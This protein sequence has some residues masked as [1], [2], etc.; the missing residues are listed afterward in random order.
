MHEHD[1]HHPPSSLAG[2][3]RA[4]GFV[5]RLVE[6][7]DADYDEARASWNGAVDRRPAAIAFASDAED[8]AAA[9]RAARA[10]GVPFTIRAGGHSVAGRSVRDGALCIDLRALNGVAGRSRTPA[11][12]RVGGGA[13]LGEVDAATQ[14]HGLAVPAGQISHTGVGGLTLGGGLGWLMRRH[15]LTIDSLV[16]AEVV[17]ADGSIVQASAGEH[18]DLF[19]ALRGGGGDFGGGHELRVPA[20]PRRPDRA[21]RDARLPVGAGGRRAAREPGADGGRPGGADDVR[22]A[23]HRAAARRRS[24]P[25]CRGS[26]SPSS[27]SR[28]AATSPTGERA[29]APLRTGLPP[30]LDLVGPMPYVALQSMLDETAPHGWNFYDRQHYLPEVGDDFIDDAAG[31][32]RARSDAARPRHDRRG[33]AAR[34]IA[35]RRARRRSGTARRAR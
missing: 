31:R 25:S 9:I 4:S 26:P 28:G 23:D 17:L 12:V 27:P 15:G 24:P 33:W 30:A 14:E 29:L 32:L 13:L 6:P 10:A 21:R 1:N 11:L 20:R 7:A 5:G 22:G 35:S 19:W 8:V 3:L 2:A 16:S 34:S 18:P